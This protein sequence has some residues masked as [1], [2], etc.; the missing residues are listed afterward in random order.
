MFSS[1]TFL[2]MMKTPNLTL[3]LLIIVSMITFISKPSHQVSYSPQTFPVNARLHKAYQALQAWKYAI[4]SDPNN[5]TANWCGPDVCSYKGVY[6]AQAVD[7]PDITTVA[8]VDLNHA[9]IAGSLPE[10]LGLL[11]DI[12][13]LHINSNNFCGTIPSSFRGL[14]LLYEL[15]I[16]NNQLSGSFPSSVLYLPSLKFLDIRYNNFEGRIPPALFDLKLDALFLNNNKFKCSLPQNIGNSTVSAIALANNNFKSGF[17][18]NLAKMKDT[19]N[20]V[21]LTN[22]GLEGCLP[23]NIG[24]LDKL[25]VFD[26][27]NNKLD[28]SLPESMGGMKSLELLNVANNGF[29]GQIP[30]S[31]CSLHKL[32]SFNS[33]SNYFCG[34]PEMCVRLRETDDRKNCI[35]CRPLQ[36]SAKECA[37]F[38][39]H[40]KHLD[41]CGA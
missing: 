35:P 25:R 13:L 28:G 22:S 7:D 18:S 8:G 26:V 38:H 41:N 6:C 34:Q 3:F 31:V 20:E 37:A 29:S 5:F 19:L 1:T 11:V 17:P 32:E 12:A 30:A 40:N 39:F 24:C 27:S 9:N 15:D 4:T 14:Y 16:S 10:E 2:Q 23:W 33:S 36:R 21:I